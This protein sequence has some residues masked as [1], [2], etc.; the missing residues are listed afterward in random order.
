MFSKPTRGSRSCGVRLH[1]HLR[2]R[3]RQAEH[4]VDVVAE[5]GA[6][7]L[8]ELV[9]PQEQPPSSFMRVPLYARNFPWI[10]RVSAANSGMPSNG[11]W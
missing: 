11:L 8:A 7:L 2:A 3:P 10:S 1:D 5:A 4:P 6:V 9:R